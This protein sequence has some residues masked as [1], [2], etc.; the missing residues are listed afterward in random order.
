MPNLSAWMGQVRPR[1]VAVRGGLHPLSA[2]RI[3]LGDHR[4]VRL[5]GVRMA[6][7][8]P[9]VVAHTAVDVAAGEYVAPG[10]EI[11]VGD[12]VVDCGANVGAFAVWAAKAGATVEAYEPHPE[13][14][15]WL[16]RNTAGL[17]VRC[18]QAAVVAAPPPEGA[19]RLKVDSH[20]DTQH[21]L[22]G[23][24]S[25]GRSIEV[26]AVSLADAIGE[27][28][29][30]LKIDTEGAEF[31]LLGATPDRALRRA[32]RIACEVHDW[33]GDPA[34]LERRLGDLGYVVRRRT[35]PNG[36]SMLFARL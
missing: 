4:D 20:A 31:D 23:S 22:G 7:P 19:V 25:G 33:H 15:E 29:D 16:R 9:R 32:R 36:L 24:S 3:G 28:C 30:L 14:F 2:L 6:G 1:V 34:E 11:E 17:T 35:K 13:T 21:T 12:R 27:G 10:F 18:V 8:N 26:P 5:R